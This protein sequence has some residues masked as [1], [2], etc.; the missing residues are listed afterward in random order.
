MEGPVAKDERRTGVVTRSAHAARTVAPGESPGRFGSLDVLQGHPA[1]LLAAGLDLQ[2]HAVRGPGRDAHGRVGS[3]D[4]T[5]DGVELARE[6]LADPPDH[7]AEQR[8][9]DV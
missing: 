3:V 7:G 5:L 1:E 8:V 2:R 4:R 9:P 6:V